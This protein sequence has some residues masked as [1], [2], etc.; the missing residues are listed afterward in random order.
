MLLQQ[1]FFISIFGRFRFFLWP[2]HLGS[3]LINS[4]AKRKRKQQQRNR[5]GVKLP[6]PAAAAKVFVVVV[7]ILVV[8]FP[9]TYRFHSSSSSG[10]VNLLTF[11]SPAMKTFFVAFRSFAIKR[12]Q[13]QPTLLLRQCG[14]GI[15]FRCCNNCMTAEAT[16][17][18]LFFFSRPK[19]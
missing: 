15:H 4:A 16:A 17:W 11:F 7:D 1:H 14:F 3:W 9:L 2:S 6:Q 8:V 12:Q 5:N 19:M 10:D 13:Q 18:I